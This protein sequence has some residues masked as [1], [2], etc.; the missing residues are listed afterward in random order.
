ME[1]GKTHGGRIPSLDGIRAFSILA[2]LTMHLAGTKNFVQYEAVEPFNLGFLGVWTFF[3]IS[4]FLITS[5]LLEEMA[6]TGKISLKAFYIRRTLRIFPCSYVFLVV[7]GIAGLVNAADLWHGFT[8]T[9]NYF[10]EGRS[11]HV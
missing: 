9:V 8:Y 3:V 7:I 4:G 11:W 1:P 5:L 10:R 2:V 6:S